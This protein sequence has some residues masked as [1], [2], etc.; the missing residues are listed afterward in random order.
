ML[1][2][3]EWSELSGIDGIDG[4]GRKS[5]AGELSLEGPI[6]RAPESV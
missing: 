4:T 3:S 2:R 5:F 6:L 1:R